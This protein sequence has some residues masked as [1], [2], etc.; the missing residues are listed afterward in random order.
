MPPI[1]AAQRLGKP[2]LEQLQAHLLHPDVDLQLQMRQAGIRRFA[3]ADSQDYQAIAQ[4]YTPADLQCKTT[5]NLSS[6]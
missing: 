1:V 2:F 5:I 4:L 3:I 6:G